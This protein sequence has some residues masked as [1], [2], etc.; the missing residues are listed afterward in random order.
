MKELIS[1]L[2]NVDL[3][4]CQE[5]KVNGM[6]YGIHSVTQTN[7]KYY[8]YLLSPNGMKIRVVL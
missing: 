8:V 1:A 7:E 5:L 6:I 4:L 2:K 3:S